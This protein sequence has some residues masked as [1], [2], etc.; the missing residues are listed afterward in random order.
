M[1][2]AYYVHNLQENMYSFL[3]LLQSFF[4]FFYSCV[5]LSFVWIDLSQEAFFFLLDFK[6]LLSLL[7]KDFIYT[8]LDKAVTYICVLNSMTFLV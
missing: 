4:L 1:V 7:S 6:V 5:N 3:D 2:F 8:S